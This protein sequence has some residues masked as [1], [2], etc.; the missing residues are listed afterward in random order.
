MQESLSQIQS[1]SIPKIPHEPNPSTSHEHLPNPAFVPH[2]VYLT[3][4]VEFMDVNYQ[5][6]GREINLPIEMQDFDG[7][8]PLNAKWH[9]AKL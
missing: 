5:G 2:N 9:V 4:Q 6:E 1:Y 3:L 7:T 8:F